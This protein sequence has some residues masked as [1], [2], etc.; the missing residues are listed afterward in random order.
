MPASPAQTNAVAGVSG[1]G[2]GVGSGV[3]SAVPGRREGERT[4]PL[5]VGLGGRP[6]ISQNEDIGRAASWLIS[7]TPGADPIERQRAAGRGGGKSISCAASWLLVSNSTGGI[8][9]LSHSVAGT[10]RGARVSGIVACHAG[11]LLPGYQGVFHARQWTNS[12]RRHLIY[13]RC[14]TSPRQMETRAPSP[15]AKH[16]RPMLCTTSFS[17]RGCSFT[18]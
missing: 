6:S 9:L 16:S 4:L 8:S 14:S 1:V 12:G 2:S 7:N 13:Q 18:P 17:P 5:Q 10:A 11:C 3:P 15:P